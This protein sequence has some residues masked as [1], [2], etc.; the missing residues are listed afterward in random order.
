MK[1]WQSTDKNEQF[2]GCSEDIAKIVIEKLP[3]QKD[4]KAI[5][6]LL[7]EDKKEQDEEKLESNNG[8]QMEG[9][10]RDSQVKQVC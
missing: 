3:H 6:Y 1:N 2:L 9:V 4:L 8:E 10:K 7:V 5:D